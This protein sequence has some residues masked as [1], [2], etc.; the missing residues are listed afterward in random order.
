MTRLARENIYLRRSVIIFAE[1][2]LSY[3][4]VFVEFR[5]IGISGQSIVAGKVTNNTTHNKE[6]ERF[7]RHVIEGRNFF[8]R[9]YTVRD[10]SKYIRM[11]RETTDMND[12]YMTKMKIAAVHPVPVAC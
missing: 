3:P 8:T 4:S 6:G 5:K 7:R 12:T 10:T 11:Y 2:S 1:D 9:H